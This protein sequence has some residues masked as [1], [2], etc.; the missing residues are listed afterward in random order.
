MLAGLQTKLWH[1]FRGGL[2]RNIVS[3]YGVQASHQVLQLLTIPFL[4]RMLGPGEWGRLAQ[5]QA[6]ALFTQLIVNYGFPFAAT[7]EVARW[8]DDPQRISAVVS[9]IIGAQSILA[10]VTA[11][12]AVIF[13]WLWLP[14]LYADP[15]LLTMAILS[16]LL[17]GII[18][19]WFFQGQERMG[20]VA[21]LEMVGK[22]TTAIGL[23][24]IIRSPQDGWKMLA[25]QATA[26]AIVF[27]IAAREILRLHRIQRPSLPRVREAFK[28]GW[29][30][31]LFTSA[32]STLAIGNVLLLGLFA[33]V[34]IVGFYAGAEKLCRAF[35][36][37]L[38]P[39]NQAIYPRVNH[40]CHTDPP[41][42]ARLVLR[43]L[44][45]MGGAGLVMSLAAFTLAPYVI[46]LVLGPGFEPAV[47]ALRMMAPMIA[48]MPI[49]IVFGLQWSVPMG[50]DRAYSLAIL[51][52]VAVNVVLAA[53]LAPRFGHLG[54][55]VS[56][57]STEL[58][59]LASLW[60]MLKKN[61]LSPFRIAAGGRVPVDA[62]P[63]DAGMSEAS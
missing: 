27:T 3:L 33:P 62:A 6:V 14:Q 18:P 35:V 9:D 61:N 38:W 53:V 29:D 60:W 46:R 39:L 15:R 30:M 57:A 12:G 2:F 58:F 19:M 54:M 42:G 24:L 1:F 25:M 41:A 7:R 40:L 4:A 59:M 20:R 47:P 21:S 55:A 10:I 44:A 43:S 8:R 31:F 37:F 50:L 32:S 48:I 26:S 51:R 13:S 49:N 34:K 45:V 23:F 17:G 16:G 5:A 63:A 52:A 11:T 56:V 36:G 28:N 22:I